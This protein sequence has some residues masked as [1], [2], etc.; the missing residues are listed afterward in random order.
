M[1]CLPPIFAGGARLCKE[2]VL[3]KSAV[4][5]VARVTRMFETE[6]DEGVC[7]FHLGLRIFSL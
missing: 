6:S 7:L 3:P 2:N 5:I 4:Y 1:S